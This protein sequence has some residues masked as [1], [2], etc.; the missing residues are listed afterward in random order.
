MAS[1]LARVSAAVRVSK[2]PANFSG[3]TR[4]TCWM[5]RRARSARW[6]SL[7]AK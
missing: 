7:R 5:V 6:A 3:E 2:K 1:A 4:Q